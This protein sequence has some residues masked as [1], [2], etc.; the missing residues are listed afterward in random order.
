MT[1]IYAGRVV[2]LRLAQVRTQDGRLVQ[3][4]IVEHAPGAGRALVRAP[5]QDSGPENGDRPVEEGERGGFTRRLR[6]RDVG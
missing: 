3:R 2:T 6:A 5:A 4:E 1:E